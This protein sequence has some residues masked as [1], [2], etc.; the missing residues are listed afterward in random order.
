MLFLNIADP[1]FNTKFHHP[2][3]QRRVGRGVEQTVLDIIADVRLRAMRR[4][5]S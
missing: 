5:W 2:F 3:T 1:D 4:C